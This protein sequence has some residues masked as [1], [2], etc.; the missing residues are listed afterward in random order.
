[1]GYEIRAMS[2][3]E[4]MDAGF[5]IVRQH[6]GLIIGIGLS[7]TRANADGGALFERDVLRKEMHVGLQA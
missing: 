6:F 3:A 1:M 4:I 5:R 7:K 2:F